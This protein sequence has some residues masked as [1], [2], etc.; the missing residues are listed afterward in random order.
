MKVI[1]AGS[2]SITDY[3][4]VEQAIL[5]SPFYVEEVVSGCARGVDQFGEQWALKTGM[6]I[7]RFPANWSLG[8]KAGMIRNREMA[9]Y[10]D[11]LIAVWDGKSHG[12]RHMIAYIRKAV[13]KPDFVWPSEA[14]VAAKEIG[15]V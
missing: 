1:I 14:Q 6:P 10:A 4:L 11:A 9:D 15:Y 5:E 7:T 3:A 8:R 12:T 2:R 13:C